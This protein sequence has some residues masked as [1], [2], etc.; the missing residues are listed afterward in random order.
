M[1]GHDSEAWQQCTSG[2]VPMLR[3]SSMLWA[4]TASPEAVRYARAA[5][6][7]ITTWQLTHEARLT[8]VGTKIADLCQSSN[9]LA[10]RG[11]NRRC[12]APARC[13]VM[14]CE[15]RASGCATG[16]KAL[17]AAL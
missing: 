17:Q 15:A 16:C 10:L 13:S 5:A 4:V 11:C 14:L 8:T 6:L 2:L 12:K 1:V 3:S 7:F 9:C